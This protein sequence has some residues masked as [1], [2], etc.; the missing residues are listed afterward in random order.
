MSISSGTPVP[1]LAQPASI[2]EHADSGTISLAIIPFPVRAM[3]LKIVAVILMVVPAM[4]SAQSVESL[5]E[6]ALANP[7]AR[8]IHRRTPGADVYVLTGS[9]AQPMLRAIADESERSI[10]ANLEWLREG[11]AKGRLKLFFVG[12]R[13]EMRPFT[14]TRSAGWSVVGEGTAFFVANDSVRPAIRHEVM[15]LLSWRLWGAPGGMWLSEGVATAAAGHCRDWSIQGIAS[16][17]YRDRQLA[18]IDDM[19]RRFRTGGTQGTVHYLSAG[20][21]VLFIDETWGRDRLRELWQSKGMSGAQNVLGV[22]PLV[23]EQRWRRRVSS[24]PPAA[25]WSVI[26]REVARTGCE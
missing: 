24:E 14:G 4:L 8:W 26:S 21:L 6:R 5:A 3:L 11:S 19:R 25:P 20:S 22:S 12:S 10:R 7:L 16:S 23:V 17:L 18:T 15:H 13:D 2:I 1:P 9:A